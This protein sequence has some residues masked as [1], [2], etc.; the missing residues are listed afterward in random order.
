[1]ILEIQ[2]GYLLRIRTEMGCSKVS[3]LAVWF[4]ILYS[5]SIVYILVFFM[6]ILVQP[7]TH[8]LEHKE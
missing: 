4:N 7:P 1:M 3:L 2:S 6:H 8:D 5:L